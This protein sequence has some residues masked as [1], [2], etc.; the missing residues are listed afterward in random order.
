MYMKPLSVIAASTMPRSVNNA[1]SSISG[2]GRDVRTAHTYCRRK[3]QQPADE[4]EDE[5]AH[6]DDAAVVPDAQVFV[7][8]LD[9]LAERHL[10]RSESASDHRMLHRRIDHD[11]PH[12][13]A[14]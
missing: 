10:T 11:R 6:P 13:G 8:W 7:V 3:L 12:R 9:V 5:Q 14:T 2:C 4:H 1:A